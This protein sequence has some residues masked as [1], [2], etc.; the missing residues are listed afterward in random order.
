MDISNLYQYVHVSRA[1]YLDAQT[2]VTMRT[3]ILCVFRN[4][5]NPKVFFTYIYKRYL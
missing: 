2:F 1:A 4:N 3:N 5:S